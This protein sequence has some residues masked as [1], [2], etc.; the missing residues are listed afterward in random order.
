M[1]TV[2]VRRLEYDARVA[3]RFPENVGGECVYR[4]RRC[5]R[6]FLGGHAMENMPAELQLQSE[7]KKSLSFALIPVSGRAGPRVTIRENKRPSTPYAA[8]ATIWLLLFASLTAGKKAFGADEQGDSTTSLSLDR[9]IVTATRTSEEES[10]IGSA[11]SQ[12]SGQQLETEQIIDLKTA[13]N[14]TPGAF[15]LE[16]ERGV[17]L[18]P[19]ASVAM[20]P[21]T[22]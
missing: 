3:S 13:L 4:A 14:T 6:V 10:G 20:P 19:S 9:V 5:E 22:P 8:V 1:G 21:A 12:L 7:S 11:F 18:R 16:G 17:V 15:A 2:A